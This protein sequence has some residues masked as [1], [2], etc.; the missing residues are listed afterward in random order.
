MRSQ[1][2]GKN[3]LAELMQLFARGNESLDRKSAVTPGKENSVSAAS[4]AEGAANH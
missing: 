2:A 3:E 4:G 1:G